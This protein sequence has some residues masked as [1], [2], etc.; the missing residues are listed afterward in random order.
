[1]ANQTRL[2]LRNTIDMMQGIDEYRA[3]KLNDEW[4]TG[5]FKWVVLIFGPNH[6]VKDIQALIA[7]EFKNL[8]V[9]VVLVTNGTTQV[10]QVKGRN[11]DEFLGDP[12]SKQLPPNVDPATRALNELCRATPE[13]YMILI[14]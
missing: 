6:S 7:G 4:I 1:M 5:P 14:E 8:N 3:H 12:N 11:K 13:G 2:A 10:T 9:I